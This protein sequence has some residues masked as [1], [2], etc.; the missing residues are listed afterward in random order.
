MI[1]LTVICM[2]IAVVFLFR[3]F[4]M[5][6]EMKRMTKQLQDYRYRYIEK[7]LDI[8]Y[9]DRDIERLAVEIN[10]Y[11][12]SMIEMKVEQ[13]RT[14]ETL[15]QAIANMSHD[16]RTPLTSI[17]GYIQLLEDE[18]LTLK[19]RAEYIGI[20]K[21]R[22]K[23]LQDLL[24][25]FFELSIVES[26][27]HELQFQT[28]HL[29]QSIWE[30]LMNYY[31]AFHERHLQ[32]DIDMPDEEIMLYADPAAVKRVVENLVSNVL[33][34]ASGSVEI[35]LKEE[36]SSIVFTIR[37]KT[38]VMTEQDVERIFD[39]FYTGDTARNKKGAGLGLSIAKSLMNKMDG[40]LFASLKNHQFIMTC[41]WKKS[42]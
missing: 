19:E 26:M 34:H 39:R 4:F 32:V 8:E 10:G 5:K 23:R 33:K 13:K 22:T 24:N 38:D 35:S 14:E 16:L 17:L 21:R 29:N 31:D 42:T 41:Q 18:H 30:V 6:R 37:N 7:K 28:F 36:S 12:D 25:E 27:D 11:F 40:E 1:H 15:K 3:L 2:F 20:V 9:F